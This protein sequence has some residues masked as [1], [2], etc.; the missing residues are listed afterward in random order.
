MAQS[1]KRIHQARRW[2]EKDTEGKDKKNK[3]KE[4]E[5]VKLKRSKYIISYKLKKKKK[6]IFWNKNP[7]TDW[8][9]GQG[10]E[11]N[12]LQTTNNNHGQQRTI[13]YQPHCIKKYK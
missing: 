4:K 8:T 11:I 7:Q 13:L 10:V 9:N 6:D 5:R 12:Y 1:R 3:E 2:Q